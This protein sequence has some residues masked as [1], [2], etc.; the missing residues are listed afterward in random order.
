[1]QGVVHRAAVNSDG[2]HPSDLPGAVGDAVVHGAQV[3][4]VE[5]VAHQQAPLGRQRALNV[6]V[7]GKRKMHRDRLAADAHFQFD[8]VVLAKQPELVQV[9]AGVQ[10]R[11]RQR[12]LVQAGAGDKA[13]TQAQVLQHVLPHHRVGVDANEGIAG[14][15]M[16]GQRFAAHKALHG[17]AQ[18]RDLLRVDD[19]DLR[20][21]RLWLGVAGGCNQGR[22]VGHGPIVL[23]P[24]RQARRGQRNVRRRPTRCYELT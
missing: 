15:Q 12:G 22:H 5:H 23:W 16:A 18:V 1:M 17:V 9:I 11:P 3:G 8:P 20:Q 4:Q 19:F 7:L 6:V 13:I 24:R 10:V 21:R 14:A 2:G